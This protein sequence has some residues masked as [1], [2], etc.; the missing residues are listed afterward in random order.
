MLP[1]SDLFRGGYRLL[2][3]DKP[4]FVKFNS[5]VIVQGITEDVIHSWAVPSLGIKF[6]VIPGRL[7]SFNF[8]PVSLGV[9][10]GQCSEICGVKH[11][12]MPIEI[13]VLK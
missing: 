4:L 6:D 7:N 11:R 9:F 12:F 2:E 13:E 8:V 10:Y 5:R 1:F 3:T